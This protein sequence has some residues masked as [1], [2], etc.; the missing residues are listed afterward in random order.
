MLSTTEERNSPMPIESAQSAISTWKDEPILR[1]RKTAEHVALQIVRNIVGAGL[2]AGDRLPME[3]EMQAQF[4]VSRAS[5][6]EALRLL[7]VQGLVTM[8]PGPRGG[9]FVGQVSATHLARS[10][11][12]YFQAAGATYDELL[13][14]WMLTEPLLAGQAAGNPDRALV[15]K[16]MM[17]F[18]KGSATCHHDMRSIAA[19]FDFHDAVSRLASNKVLA[20][21]LNG[22]GFIV[23]EHIQSVTHR[24]ELEP[25]IIDDHKGLADAIIA[26]HKVLAQRLMF[27]HVQHLVEDF[28]A[29][30]PRKIGENIEWR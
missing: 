10:L 22:I 5:L 24:A 16:L 27:E 25:A 11:T 6:R 13:E 8:R 21:V 9:A 26:G 4:Q 18:R 1:T 20:L 29:Y 2:A 28:R 30:W 3:S 23:A 17:P 12:L 7:E 19:G 14:T 15:T